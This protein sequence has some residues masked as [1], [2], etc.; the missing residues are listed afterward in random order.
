MRIIST[1]ALLWLL[2]LT[3][4]H[5]Q[6]PGEFY[7]GKTINIVVGFSSGGGYDLYARLLARHMPQYIPGKPIIVVQN[8]PGAGSLT[9]VRNLDQRAPQDGTVIV[10]FNP[11]LIIENLTAE[12]TDTSFQNLAWLGSISKDFRVCYAWNGTPVRKW[13]DLST[14]QT[15]VLGGTAVGSSSYINGAM[16]RNLFGLNIRQVTGYPGSAE[17]RLAI[18]RGELH[19]DCGTWSAIT[20]EWRLQNKITGFVRFSKE[21]TPDMP[22]GAKFIGD[23]AK[24]EEQTKLVDFLVSPGE[25]GVP[26]VLSKNVPSERLAVL[27][28]AFDKTMKDPQFV[29]DAQKMQFPV[30]PVNGKEAE[31]IVNRIYAYPADIVKKAASVIK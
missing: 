6:S 28:D 8:M 12:K 24:T 26:Y 31:Q 19:G 1:V 23:F 20:P 30:Y 25:L 7:Q 17:V 10:A 2:G 3:A 13:E 15:F 21:T 22:E 11:G 29:L 9:A 4:S 18:E 5:A 27:R 14:G 16:L